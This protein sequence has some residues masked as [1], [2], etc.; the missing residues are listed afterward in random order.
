MTMGTKT[1]AA[2]LLLVGL[3]LVNYLATSVPAR[4]DA[5]A[6]RVYTLSPGTKAILSK[7]TEPTSL[8]L[9][10]S[11]GTSGQFVE[12]KN[13][14]ERVREML[15]QYVR[16]SKGKVRL[17][18][19][20]PEPDTPQEE[21]ATAAGVE[22]QTIPGGS[23]FYFGLVATQADQ[24]RAIPALTPQREQFLEYDVS[25][26]IYAVGQT[27]K[28]KLGLLTSLP[29]QGSP[30]MP[31][32]GQQGEEGQFIASEWQD[33]YQI[34]PVEPSGTELPA[35]LDVLA[36]VHPENV[37]P[38]L[39]FAIDQF[40]LSGKPVF[41]AVDPSSVYFKRQGGQAAM[42][43]GPQPNV[44]SDLPALLSGWGIAY[45]PQKI[46]GDNENAEEVELRDQSTMRYPVWIS[47][48]Q[49]AFNPKA[50]P[51]AQLES[52][53]FIEA[54]SISLKP[55]CDLTFTPLVETSA[56]TGEIAAAAIQFAQP[57]DV[58][59]Q[60]VPSGKR[61]IAA[62]VSGKFKS[63]FPDGPPRE[64][65]PADAA[66]KDKDEKAKPAPA[67]PSLRESRTT[68]LLIVVA[69]TDWLMD[70][71][72]VHKF[73]YMGQSAATPINDNLALA[74]N[75]LDY[76]AG[77]HDLVS[78][79]G[80]GDS[81]RPFTVVRKMEARA[82]EKYREKLTAL[83]AQ[84][85]EVQD[86]LAEL[87]GQ[88]GEGGR[89]LASPEATRAIEDFQKQSAALRGERRAIRL[90][91]RQGIDALENW[92]LVINLLTTPVLVCAFGLWYNLRCRR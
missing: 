50:L 6:E 42:F 4:L 68:S 35:D 59:R 58:A 44:S 24:Q 32:M 48:T 70:E 13:Y 9:Y 34:A 47:L 62:I 18:V 28:K 87:Q 80:K 3:V 66:K 51:T 84:I 92:L 83:E 40:L 81:V 67:A 46:V 30:G 33:T 61:T 20:D 86:K 29:L 22:P 17:N 71:Y 77:S 85:K 19:I 39:Q 12:Y 53:L 60:L 26:L 75:C 89:L 73:N 27:E 52:A 21:K 16:S 38:K 1:V 54:G 11:R 43:G 8:D 31:M 74:A 64:P 88:K 90:S 2:A 91:L 65:E 15:R 78:I 37:S 7:I 23:Q 36:I 57:E 45:D 14:A 63:A 82:A 79:R 10:Y 55:G 69:D 49:D 72:S 5:T 76:L 25:E 41:L 56:K